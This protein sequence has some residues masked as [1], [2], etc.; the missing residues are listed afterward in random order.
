MKA[1]TFVFLVALALV[2]SLTG[3]ILAQDFTETWD[4]NTVLTVFND[5]DMYFPDMFAQ[6]DSDF[7]WVEHDPADY[8]NGFESKSVAK[9]PI[10]SDPV[11]AMTA[12][13]DPCGDGLIKYD[14]TIT[15][16]DPV[17]GSWA[18]YYG[19][20]NTTYIRDIEA[21]LTVRD[22]SGSGTYK[23]GIKT[24]ESTG[25]DNC[26]SV[27]FRK[28]KDNTYQAH[29]KGY[30]TVPYGLIM[31][32]PDDFNY[33]YTLSMDID[34][35]TYM[36]A[37]WPV[38]SG[39]TSDTVS[40]SGST[41]DGTLTAS[42]KNYCQESLV[43]YDAF[44]YDG[45]FYKNP[46]IR[47]KYDENTGEARLQVVIANHQGDVKRQNY[48]IPGEVFAFTD[49]SVDNSNESVSENGSRITD[50]TCKYTLYNVANAA[51]RTD[52]CRFGEGIAIPDNGMV[53]IDITIDALPGDILREAGG[54][55]VY[56]TLRL[57]G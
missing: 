39:I 37:L 47:G 45:N 19:D 38:D 49:W 28:Q 3:G 16:D 42:K 48:L 24:C 17:T 11:P 53:R 57:G 21:K 32:D 34:F 52:Y 12:T 27:T 46:A 55:P 9:A 15:K 43:Q 56:F 44:D 4:E 22:E 36:T 2:L 10:A 50:Y 20:I 7:L 25:G 26:H 51:P 23:L 40:A 14:I 31:Y 13:Y 8:P 1:K 35:S 18:G 6:E 30:L 5:L 41:S 54:D 29:L 33:E